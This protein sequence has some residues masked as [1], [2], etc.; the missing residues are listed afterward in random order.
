[1]TISTVLRRLAASV[2]LVCVLTLGV[3]S[4]APS[5]FADCS[6]PTGSSGCKGE[7]AR[8]VRAP[9]DADETLLGT[10]AASIGELLGR[11]FG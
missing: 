7:T 10:I 3:A 8:D 11:L 1:M 2:A 4:F 9:A 5:T 6:T